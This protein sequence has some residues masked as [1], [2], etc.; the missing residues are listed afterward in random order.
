MRGSIPAEG[1]KEAVEAFISNLSKF[2][3]FLP[4]L[5]IVLRR[6]APMVHITFYWVRVRVQIVV[7]KGRIPSFRV[8]SGCGPVQ[9]PPQ[10]SSYW[11]SSCGCGYAALT[12]Q[13][14][15]SGSVLGHGPSGMLLL[16]AVQ[17]LL[18]S[19]PSANVPITFSLSRTFLGLLEY[20]FFVH[21]F[22]YLFILTTFL[23]AFMNLFLR[24]M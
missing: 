16:V 9:V 3:F 21:S 13:V 19:E 8:P 23:L 22:F 20:L 1:G 7:S 24:K 6:V 18:R 4:F 17:P 11:G 15:N 5:F 10:V 2:F 14:K 12:I